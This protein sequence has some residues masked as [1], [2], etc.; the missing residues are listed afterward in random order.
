MT[1]YWRFALVVP[2][3]FFLLSCSSLSYYVQSIHGHFS[4]MSQREQI[5]D[6]LANQTHASNLIQ[7]PSEERQ[8]QLKTALDIRDFATRH[9][10]LPDNDSYRS[11][12]DLKREHVVWNVVATP[13]FSMQPKTSCFAIVGCLSYRGYFN[14]TDAE[15]K[16]AELKTEGYDVYIGGVDAYSTLGWFDDPVLSSM[17]ARGDI[18]LADV[19][20]HEL[21]HQQLYVK[22]DTLFNEAFASTV[23]QE[24]VRYWLSETRPETLPRYEKWLARKTAFLNLL[25]ETSAELK[26]LYAED[27][28]EA[29]MREKKQQLFDDLRERYA[30]LRESWQGYAGFDHW[31][32]KPINNA[33]FALISLYYK[34][35]PEFQQ[36]LKACNGDFGRFYQRMEML[37]NLEKEERHQVLQEEAEC[38]S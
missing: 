24:G 22:N 28:H 34:K 6:L 12:V 29:V 38:V 27:H 36:W 25:H 15:A 26:A 35:I 11:F 19:I 23:G 4:L 9:L 30:L 37:G 17:L 31:F 5:A 33:R 32:E 1:M 7:N 2:L 10:Q 16:A 13:E 18:L 20:F 3:S 8:Q 21:A 14:K